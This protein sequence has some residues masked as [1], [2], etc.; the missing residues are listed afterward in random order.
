MII[1]SRTG[2]V[3]SGTVKT[4]FT[5]KGLVLGIMASH[6]QA[7]VETFALYDSYIVDAAYLLLRVSVAVE[8]TPVKFAF[9]N[10]EKIYFENGLTVDAGDCDVFV[11]VETL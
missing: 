4:I 5:G 3:E 11:I 10:S 7:T 2:F 8:N 1:N 6:N 9:A